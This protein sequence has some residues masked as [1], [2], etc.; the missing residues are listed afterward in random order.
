M[1]DILSYL[2]Y[3]DYLRDHYTTNKKNHPF[4]S[5]RYIAIKTGIDASFYIKILNKKKHISESTI[6]DLIEFLKLNRTESDY[7]T[8]LVHF[9]KA[10]QRDQEQFYFEKLVS[11]RDTPVKTIGKD[12]YGSFS[13]WR[14]IACR[15]ELNVI[16]FSGD[17][18]DLASKFIPPV[19]AIQARKSISL[20][21]KLGMIRKNN[22]GVYKASEPFIASDG[23]TQPQD[24]RS[25]QKET[26]NLAIDALDRIPKQERDITTLT[27]STTRACF[28][29]IRE[30]L[31]AIRNE[32]IELV[33]KETRAEEVYQIN[34]QIFPLTQNAVKE[35]TSQ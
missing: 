9:N 21:E 10:K 27:V 28:E 15:E 17:Y 13:S 34:F 19:T 32:I 20:L 16:T 11:L 6:S 2:D 14:N 29:T 3:R 7:F 23:M 12:S 1:N 18:N 22:H 30:R 24:V 33:K 8:T 35:K 31:A 4:F 26:L 5:F 25:F